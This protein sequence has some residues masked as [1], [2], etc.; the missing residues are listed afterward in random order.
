MGDV[1]H[2]DEHTAIYHVSGNAGTV[3]LSPP[4]LLTLIPYVPLEG[5]S[6]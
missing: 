4:F 3:L 6:L 5:F 1:I 2:H